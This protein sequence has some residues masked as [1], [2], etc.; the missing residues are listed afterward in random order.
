M[1]HQRTLECDRTDPLAARF[2]QIL[3]PILNLDGAVGVDRDDVAG[4]E[5]PIVGKSIRAVGP[6]VVRGRD[7]RTSYLE[8]THRQAVPRDEPVLVARTDLDERCRPALF[9]AV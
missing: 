8:L 1:T 7:P 9:C 6:I 5:P 3:G 2:D 4:L